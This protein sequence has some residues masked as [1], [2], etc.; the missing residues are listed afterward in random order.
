M[1]TQIG[2]DSSLGD[3]HAAGRYTSSLPGQGCWGEHV[4]GN[5][6]TRGP[7]RWHQFSR[8]GQYRM[9]RT[10]ATIHVGNPT[11]AETH[12]SELRHRH[13]RQRGSRGISL[14]CSKIACRRYCSR[15]HCAVPRKT[16]LHYHLGQWQQTNLYIRL[17]LRAEKHAAN[18]RRRNYSFERWGDC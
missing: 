2:R 16:V 4:C 13:L 6:P 3:D 7:T 14:W 12:P 9:L 17:Q 10:S 18:V 1:R 8:R 15:A 11:V 5:G